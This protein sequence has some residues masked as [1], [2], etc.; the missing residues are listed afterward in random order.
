MSNNQ[1]KPRTIILGLPN[2]NHPV[3]FRKV[4]NF[5]NCDDDYDY[6]STDSGIAFMSKKDCII[7]LFNIY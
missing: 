2:K 6:E 5:C 4:L 1:D 7:K 3:E